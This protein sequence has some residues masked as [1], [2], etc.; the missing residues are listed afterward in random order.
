M[1]TQPN[2]STSGT[3]NGLFRVAMGL[4]FIGLLA[5]VA[6]FAINIFSDTPPGLALYLISLACPVGFLLA[7]VYTLRAGRRAR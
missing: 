6:I 3:G 4:F 7:I 1:D 2:P 5:L